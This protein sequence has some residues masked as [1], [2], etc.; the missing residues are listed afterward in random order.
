MENL[1][2]VSFSGDSWVE[3]LHVLSDII[4]KLR[5]TLGAEPWRYTGEKQEYQEMCTTHCLAKIRCWGFKGQGGKKQK[6]T[7][8]LNL[9]VNVVHSRVG[10]I[11]TLAL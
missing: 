7:L 11:F 10:F 5:I 3:S 1:A 6:K 4:Y 2:D 9:I 8:I